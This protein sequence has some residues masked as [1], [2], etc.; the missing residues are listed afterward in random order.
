MAGCLR[1]C[2]VWGSRELPPP[3]VGVRIGE[4]GLP[5]PTYRGGG[6]VT[7]GLLGWGSA[8]HAVPSVT[9]HVESVCKVSGGLIYSVFT[10]PS[11]SD[12]FRSWSLL[13]V[14]G[15][16]IRVTHPGRWNLTH[17][18]L[19]VSSPP[20]PAGSSGLTECWCDLSFVSAISCLGTQSKHSFSVSDM[21]FFATTCLEVG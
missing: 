3:P 7:P 13:R 18:D 4:Q 2:T 15:S 16:Q 5:V 1:E 8:E 9:T 17:G 6:R 10:W 11:C 12:A 20:A 21:G 19:G 14:V